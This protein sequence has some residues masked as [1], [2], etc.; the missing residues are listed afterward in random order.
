MREIIE[1]VASTS[2]TESHKKI[3]STYLT[4]AN[5]FVLATSTEAKKSSGLDGT[6]EKHAAWLRIKGKFF[7]PS[8]RR[9]QGYTGQAVPEGVS[10]G[11]IC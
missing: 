2:L 8:L 5:A 11:R 7:S 1:D 6:T 9:M 4:S 10:M 3:P